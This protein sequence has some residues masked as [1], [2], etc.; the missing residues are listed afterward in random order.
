MPLSFDHLVCPRQQIGLDGQAD[1]LRRLQINHQL[2][3]RWL[4]HRQVVRLA[5][6]DSVDL[7]G[8]APVAVW[9]SG[10]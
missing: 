8:Y 2:E 9:S 1:L 6:N 5:F 4:L 10:T 3:F 7:I